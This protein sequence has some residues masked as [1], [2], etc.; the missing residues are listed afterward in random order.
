MPDYRV[1]YL[2]MVMIQGSLIVTSNGFTD[3]IPTSLSARAAALA[4]AT[5]SL[6]G[7]LSTV[8]EVE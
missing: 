6:R 8:G 7:S 1:D 2:S 4:K 3:V 5:P